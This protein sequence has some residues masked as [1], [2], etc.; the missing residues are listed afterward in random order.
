VGSKSRP[1]LAAGVALALL[2]TAV[3]GLAAGHPPEEPEHGIDESIFPIL[4]SGDE[5]GNVTAGGDGDDEAIAVRQLANGTD[6]PLNSPPE[7][8]GMWNDGELGE[9]PS[10]D[11]ETS[12][13][14]FGIG[15]ES[16]RFVKNAHVTLFAVQPSTRAHLS[17][18]HRPLYVGSDGAVLGTADYRVVVPE[19]DTNGTKQV[20]WTLESHRINETRLLVD[21]EEKTTKG[22]SHTP[23]LSFE[24]LKEG[25]HEITLAANVTARVEE[26]IRNET[27]VCKRKGNETTCHTE[28]NH[29]YIHHNETV[30]VTD[31][32]EVVVYDLQLSVQTAQ[33]PNGDM[34]VAVTADRPWLGYSFPDSDVVGTWRFY[35]ARDPGWDTLIRVSQAGVSVEHSPLHPLQLHAVPL[36]TGASAMG[37]DA[38]VVAT[39]G[40]QR[41]PP[42]LP[43]NI[44]LD[45]PSDRYTETKTIVSRVSGNVSTIH[46]RGLVRGVGTGVDIGSRD[47]V[48]IHRSTLTLSVVGELESGTSVRVTLRDTATGAPIQTADREGYVVIGGERVNT[49]ESGTATVTLEDPGTAVSARYEPSNWWVDAPGYEPDSETI[50]VG[51]PSLQLVVTVSKFVIPVG[52]FLLAV[53]FV[54]RVTQWRIWPPWRGL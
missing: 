51:P 27:E 43:A 1:T 24:D 42:T 19:N 45:V 35:S 52:L 50:I 28:V 39:D 33:Y 2:A 41:E 48:E 17:E 3:V 9:F 11:R 7:A 40:E 4:W 37:P 30:T 34:A 6:I 31:Q 18:S 20:Y 13:F 29:T 54:D 12:A 10:T 16:G 53:F 32:V 38:N 22:G 8:I 21:G 36:F 15:T 44:N 49:T 46:A 14:P 47:P 5:D 23:Q 26:H 25:E